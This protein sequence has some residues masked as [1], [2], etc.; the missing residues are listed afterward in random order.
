MSKPKA[1][2]LSYISKNG[3]GFDHSPYIYNLRPYLGLQPTLRVS[4][5]HSVHNRGKERDPMSK[6]IF[7][8]S[9]LFLFQICSYSTTHDANYNLRPYLGLQPTLRVSRIHSVHNSGKERDPMSK[10]ISPEF[11]SSVLISGMGNS[12]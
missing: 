6:T 2:V 8:L 3:L 4:R 10:T 1:W 9:D 11:Q 5:I 12:G 7:L